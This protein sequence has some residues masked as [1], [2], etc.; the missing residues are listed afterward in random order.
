MPEV[1]IEIDGGIVRSAHGARVTVIDYDIDGIDRNA[2]V[3]DRDAWVYNAEPRE[4]RPEILTVD[5]EVEH[6]V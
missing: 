1:I 2:T 5:T 4:D 6:D 3:E